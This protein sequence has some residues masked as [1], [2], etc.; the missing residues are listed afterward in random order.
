MVRLSHKTSALV[1]RIFRFVIS[2]L[3]IFVIANVTLPG[4]Q[5]SK[6]DFAIAGI[7]LLLLRIGWELIWTAK[8]STR[9][10]SIAAVCLITFAFIS[11]LELAVGIFD[12]PFSGS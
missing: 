1:F 4:M 9:Q 12:L 10:R 2:I 8:Q 7:F 5:W 6:S 11:W 3:L